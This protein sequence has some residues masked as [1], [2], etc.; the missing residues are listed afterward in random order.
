MIASDDHS[1][2]HVIGGNG[3]SCDVHFRSGIPELAHILDVALCSGRSEAP[4]ERAQAPTVSTLVKQK[5]VSRYAL[6]LSKAPG[7]AYSKY[8]IPL[9]SSE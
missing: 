1:R 9:L 6:L 8:M 7:G 5:V 4:L 3:L 2:D